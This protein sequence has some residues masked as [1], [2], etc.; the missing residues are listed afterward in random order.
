MRA[1]REI[2][3]VGGHIA[4]LS[5]TKI[6]FKCYL[7]RLIIIIL[8][9]LRRI[10]REEH[11]RVVSQTRLLG[12]PIHNG[13]YL[14]HEKSEF[15][16]EW[17]FLR[18]FT[19]TLY[20]RTLKILN[21]IEKNEYIELS[22]SYL[23]LL[24]KWNYKPFVFNVNNILHLSEKI[25][26]F[27]FLVWVEVV[28]QNEIW[29]TIIKYPSTQWWVLNL[30]EWPLWWMR[31]TSKNNILPQNIVTIYL[32]SLSEWAARS[33]SVLVSNIFWWKCLLNLLKFTTWSP[34]TLCW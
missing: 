32:C 1:A 31:L 12:P 29:E 14:C 28:L 9:L 10:R 26:T 8:L 21:K 25:A 24:S 15:E 17:T 23:S 7:S 33:T 19:S 2:A 6:Y 20:T 5:A 18:I 13:P 4:L 3:T 11:C 30:W 22:A 16:C 27:F 34:F